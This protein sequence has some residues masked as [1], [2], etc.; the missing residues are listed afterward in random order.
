MSTE[1]MFAITEAV[2]DAAV[3]AAL[4]QMRD[5]DKP[6]LRLDR[7]GNDAVAAIDKALAELH[8]IRSQL[9]TEV[10]QYQDDCN[11]RVDALLAERRADR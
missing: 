4:W 1:P 8:E 11:A 3:Y 5:A 10:R 9:V 2:A 6:S 7:A